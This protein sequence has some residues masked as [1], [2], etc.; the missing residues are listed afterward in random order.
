MTSPKQPTCLVTG[1]TSG[2]G[3]ATANALASQGYRVVFIGRNRDKCLATLD[4]I[5]RSTGNP[6]VD[7]LVADLSVLDQVRRVAK[8]YQARYDRLDVLINNAGGFFWSR[9]VSADGFEMTLALNHLSPFLL[10][11]L[12]LD[13]L[14]SSAP[15][16][17]VNVSSGAHPGAKPDLDDLQMEQGR[18]SGFQAYSRSKLYNLWFTYELARRLS[19]AQ[20]EDTQVTVNAVHPGWINTSLNTGNTGCIGWLMKPIVSLAAK[21]PQV[22]AERVMHVATSPELEGVSGQYFVDKQATRSSDESYD[23]EKA[24]RMWQISEDLT[25]SAAL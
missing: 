8:E 2:I 18:Y 7:Y 12:L 10:T 9:Q 25:H 5:Q 24:R 23:Q 16:R 22:G 19:E 21:D 14:N 20:G 15:A 1:A 13:L 17:I 11:N 3:K 6:L 4:E